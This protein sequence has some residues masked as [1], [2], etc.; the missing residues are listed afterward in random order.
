MLNQYKL[1]R[2]STFYD[3][4]QIQP[5]L[6]NERLNYFR[7]SI[8]YSGDLRRASE[9]EW[10]IQGQMHTASTHES[11]NPSCVSGAWINFMLRYN[12]SLFEVGMVYVATKAPKEARATSQLL[13]QVISLLYW[14]LLGSLWLALWI[15]V[16]QP[17]IFSRPQAL[18]GCFIRNIDGIDISRNCWISEHLWRQ[19]SHNTIVESCE[20]CFIIHCNSFNPF[21]TLTD[22]K[23]SSNFSKLQDDCS[24]FQIRKTNHED[25]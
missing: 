25:A 23:S 13:H 4:K 6:T 16:C 11:A 3:T 1:G 2:T 22:C 20:Y 18:V 24:G 8:L 9:V 10:T 7:T 19:T 14:H 17:V 5:N 15:A 12:A 21:Q